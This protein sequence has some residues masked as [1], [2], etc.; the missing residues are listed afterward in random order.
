MKIYPPGDVA[1]ET[2]FH[3]E[4]KINTQLS[5]KRKQFIVKLQS[6]RSRSSNEHTTAA[7]SLVHNLKQFKSIAKFKSFQGLLSACIFKESWK[8]RTEFD[9]RWRLSEHRRL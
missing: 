2:D 7:G 4:P 9:H 1:L 5:T 3:Q 8:K 6:S